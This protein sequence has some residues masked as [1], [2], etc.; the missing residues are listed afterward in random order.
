MPVVRVG[1]VCVDGGELVR[2]AVVVVVVMGMR[3]WGKMR[4]RMGV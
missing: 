1:L 3:V 2:V 4:V